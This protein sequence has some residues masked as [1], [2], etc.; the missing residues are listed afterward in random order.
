MSWIVSY[1]K[2]KFSIYSHMQW[3]VKNGV[4]GFEDICDVATQACATATNGHLQRKRN[5]VNVSL[6][7]YRLRKTPID[8]PGR[9][10]F[11]CDENIQGCLD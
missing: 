10:N 5:N 4:R 3:F 8:S 6:L 9:L 11:A 2:Q 1:C 7:F